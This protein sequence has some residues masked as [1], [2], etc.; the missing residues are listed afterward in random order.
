LPGVV[1]AAGEPFGERRE[2]RRQVAQRQPRQ[3]VVTELQRAFQ[4]E[5]LLRPVVGDDA[6][7][8]EGVRVRGGRRDELDPLLAEHGLGPD[9]GDGV[10]GDLEALFDQQ[11][12]ARRPVAGEGDVAYPADEDPTDLHVAADGQLLAHPAAGEDRAHGHAGLEP[13]L[14]EEP[15]QRERAREEA[16]GDQAQQRVEFR[17]AIPAP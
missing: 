3:E 12:D 5:G 4:L 1:F 7:G 8:D 11:V 2:H 14:Q 16:Q 15:R 9:L 17:G 10:G 6:P 13:A